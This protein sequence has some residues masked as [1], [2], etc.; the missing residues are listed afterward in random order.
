MA[1]CGRRSLWSLH[2]QMGCIDFCLQGMCSMLSI[3]YRMTETHGLVKLLFTCQSDKEKSL[4]ASFVKHFICL[5]FLGCF[6][7]FFVTIWFYC[8]LILIFTCPLKVLSS[9]Q[10][11][12]HPPMYFSEIDLYWQSRILFDFLASFWTYAIK[13]HHSVKFLSRVL[14]LPVSCILSACHRCPLTS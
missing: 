12:I 5:P 3:S 7:L 11:F 2:L 9:S 1:R 10:W 4:C 13:S 6:R 8:I 14:S